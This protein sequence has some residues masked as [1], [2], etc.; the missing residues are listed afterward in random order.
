MSTT[1]D[2]KPDKF[3][4]YR[5]ISDFAIVTF[6]VP[7]MAEWDDEQW[8]SVARTDLASYVTEPEAYWEDDQWEIEDGQEQ[9]ETYGK[10]TL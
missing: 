6:N 5:F 7:G 3:I 2:W 4:T 10:V 1:D 9:Y 8:D